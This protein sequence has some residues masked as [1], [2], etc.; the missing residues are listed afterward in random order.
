VAWQSAESL[1]VSY[2]WLEVAGVDAGWVS[3]AE[4][5]VV[6]VYGQSGWYWSDEKFVGES[7]WL[8]VAFAFDAEAAVT[9]FVECP[10]P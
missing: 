6:V 2:G 8:G 10:G 1:C 3:A 7:V 9:L 5:G 4:V